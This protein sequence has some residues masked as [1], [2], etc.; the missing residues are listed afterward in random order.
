MAREIDMAHNR[1]PDIVSMIL[2]VWLFVT[3]FAANIPGSVFW[4]MIVFGVILFGLSWIRLYTR[5]TTPSWLN[6][7]VGVWLFIAPFALSAGNTFAYWNLTIS[8]AIAVVMALWSINSSSTRPI[9][10]TR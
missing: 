4:N 2:G 8:G 1:T 10:T 6:L 3:A 5:N 9:T 7:L